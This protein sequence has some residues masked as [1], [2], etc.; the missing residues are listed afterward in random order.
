MFEAIGGGA[1]RVVREAYA[2]A[3][4]PYAAV[5]GAVLERGRGGRQ[6]VGATASQVYF[7]AVQPLPL[8]LLI[9]VTV[10]FFAIVLSD[11]LMRPNGLAPHVPTVV[12]QSIVRELVP[13]VIAVVL[14]G[15]SGTA[16]A[17][18]LGYMR[19]NEEIEALD[20]A[21]VNI[22]Y[23]LVLPR[24]VGATLASMALT[25]AMSA[26]AL[27]GGFFLGAALNMVSVGL[28]FDQV[29]EAVTLSTLAYSA[30]KAL[31]FGVVVSSVNCFHGL[32]VGRSFTE[33]P[34][35]NV[36]GSVQCYTT[37]FFLNSVV[38]MYAMA[39]QFK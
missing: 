18:E 22:D 4:L 10:G 26:S 24:V 38:S 9:S 3:M 28:R 11:A 35:A 6:V 17:T 2:I 8:F 27:H 23:F 21:G 37:C 12:A 30:L 29:L 1:I 34:R 5:K 13:I 7:T 31:L 16:M 15:R 33:I 32:S 19:V 14:I 36:R 25:G 39:E 20:A